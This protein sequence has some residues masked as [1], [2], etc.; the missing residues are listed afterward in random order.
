DQ[1]A[2][3][4]LAVRGPAAPLRSPRHPW[5]EMFPEPPRRHYTTTGQRAVKAAVKRARVDRP[6]ARHRP[7]GRRAIVR[8]FSAMVR[9][10][11]ALLGG[12]E[13]RPASGSTALV[14]GKKIQALLAILAV[15]PGQ[16]HARDRLAS[17][18]WADVGADQ[19]RHS[20]RQALFSLRRR[21]PED[22]LRATGET[23]AM[24]ADAVAV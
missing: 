11:L 10:S 5:R 1:W 6:T 2:A 24:K 15:R 3:R 16:A 14:L 12:F 8:G 21:L 18:L 17:L 22:V 13:V 4:R 7:A 9:L 20:V 23:V 19:A